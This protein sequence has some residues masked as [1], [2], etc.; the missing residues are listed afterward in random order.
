MSVSLSPIC[1]SFTVAVPLITFFSK[2]TSAVAVKSMLLKVAVAVFS[3]AEASAGAAVYEQVSVAPG[4]TV[5]SVAPPP[6]STAPVVPSL[7]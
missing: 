7:S 1:S 5:T 4:A 3:V 6:Q 2:F